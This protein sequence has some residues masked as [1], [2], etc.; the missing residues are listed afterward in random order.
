MGPDFDLVRQGHKAY[1][2]VGLVRAEEKGYGFSNSGQGFAYS[3]VGGA[4]FYLL[5]DARGL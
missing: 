1:E 5:G 2:A 4:K 3:A